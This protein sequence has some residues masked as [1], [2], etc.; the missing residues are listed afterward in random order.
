MQGKSKVASVLARSRMV[1]EVLPKMKRKQV[2]LL[3]PQL[4]KSY[5][6]IIIHQCKG[7]YNND[8]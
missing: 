6:V 2:K 4:Y 8:K 3:M 1:V 7:D 5:M